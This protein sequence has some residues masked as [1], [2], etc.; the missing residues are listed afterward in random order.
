MSDILNPAYPFVVEIPTPGE[1]SVA[2]DARGYRDQ[3][4]ASAEEAAASA[5]EAAAI[6]AGV[7]A[8]ANSVFRPTRAALVS[9]LSSPPAWLLP[10]TLMI[11]FDTGIMW[12]YTGSG[13]LIA[14]MPGTVP[15]GVVTPQHVG[16]VS[17][18]ATQPIRDA[19][20][21][22]VAL[23]Q[24]EIRIPPGAYTVSGE[25]VIPHAIRRIFGPG[26]RL[27]MTLG[28]PLFT[29]YGNTA[30][31]AQFPSGLSAGGRTISV[32][33]ASTLYS[34]G[35]WVLL[36]SNDLIP[37]VSAGARLS[38][39][40]LIE[41]TDGNTLRFDA[42]ANRNMNTELTVRKMAMAPPIT[43]E[44]LQ[45]EH[46]NQLQ[47][48]ALIR[49]LLTLD[50]TFINCRIGHHGGPAVDLIYCVNGEW[51]N[52]HAYDLRDDTPN[53][54]AG[55]GLALSGACRGFRFT[56]GTCRRVR[57]AVTT[58]ITNPT[59]LP[60][61]LQ[62]LLGTRGE[63]EF[64]TLGPSLFAYD[65]TNI[66]F[67]THPVGFNIEIIPHAIGCFGGVNIRATDVFVNGGLLSA[68]QREGIRCTSGP[69]NIPDST[70]IRSRI[71]GTVISGLSVGGQDECVGIRMAVNGS[72]FEI[73]GVRINGVRDGIIVGNGM[74]AIMR[75]VMIDC[76]NRSGST[77]VQIAGQNSDID[78]LVIRNATT[79]IVETA[80][81]S[82]N[83]WTRVR[84]DNV[85]TAESRVPTYNA[86]GV[87][88]SFPGPFADDA[89]AAS[90]GVAVGQ[91]YRRTADNL[92]VV[93]TE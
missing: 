28:G 10:D 35:D 51:I 37:T 8:A 7:E 25:I 20:A 45:I 83:R 9:L 34:Q 67:D 19:M 26:A 65:T 15:V 43:L 71:S 87:A 46:I 4:A 58:L 76:G 38:I 44:G 49:F 53:G 78:G 90:G 18:N 24:D 66:A 32:Q 85:G 74:R 30:G 31:G 89:A 73:E 86:S 60:A 69:T 72:E 91:A 16:D 27:T 52:T 63:P 29:R 13:I 11:A 41:S 22:A 92:I 3:S 23:G 48:A 39:L 59:S 77:G 68:C 93:R 81:G 54:H 17:T 6:V 36:R 79:G 50:P 82:G 1:S 80:T 84:M 64:C 55:Y 2:E 61:E 40:R 5:E 21:V 75:D 33:N 14:D 47:S 57:H 56:S 62:D 12:H 88:Q 42:P 70:P